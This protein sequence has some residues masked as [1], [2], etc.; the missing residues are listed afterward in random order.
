VVLPLSVIVIQFP[1]VILSVIVVLP[2]FLIVVEPRGIE[3]RT[4]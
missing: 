4:S 1:I 3:P 2:P